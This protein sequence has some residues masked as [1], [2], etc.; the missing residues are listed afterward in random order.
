MSISETSICN[1]ALS[2]LNIAPIN[3][4]LNPQTQAERACSLWYHQCRQ[5][6]LR[7]HTWSF[8]T[9][10]LRPNFDEIHKAYKLPIDFI[11]MASFNNYVIKGHFLYEKCCGDFSNLGIHSN[12]SCCEID[13]IYDCNDVNVFDTLFRNLL[14]T[15]L[16]SR[17]CVNLTGDKQ[18]AQSLF[19]EYV[20]L[21]QEAK[22]IDSQDSQK[23][24]R[25]TGRNYTYGSLKFYR[26]W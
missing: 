12:I 16:A 21:L 17:I 19:A 5:Q 11:R 26:P 2:R 14:I 20:G 22:S 6:I 23:L 25:I 24:K 9:T 13:Y 1:M 18:L 4:I 8:A 3:S 10:K 7:E 15:F